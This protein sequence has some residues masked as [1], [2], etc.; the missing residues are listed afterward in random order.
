MKHILYR[1]K[2]TNIAFKNYRLINSKLCQP[3]FNILKFY[4]IIYFIQY[5]RD[6][7][8]VVNYNT[9]YSKPVHK[10]FLIAFYNKT[11]KKMYNLQILQYNI[12]YINITIMKNIIILEK[13]RE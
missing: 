12:Y 2:K 11:N 7:G 5:I 1:L 4:A 6:Y 13:I 10:Y 3:T 8:S 9:I